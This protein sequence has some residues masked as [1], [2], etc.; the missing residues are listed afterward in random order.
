MKMIYLSLKQSIY[1]ILL[2]ELLFI[3]MNINLKLLDTM[4]F[5]VEKANFLIK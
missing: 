1:S 2:K 5:I 4:D 3:S